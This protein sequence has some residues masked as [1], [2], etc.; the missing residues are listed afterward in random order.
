TERGFEGGTGPFNSRS[1]AAPISVLDDKV[2][3]GTEKTSQERRRRT[4]YCSRRRFQHH[5]PC[6]AIG[7]Q[8]T[9]ASARLRPSVKPGIG[10]Q[11]VRMTDFCH[12]S[13]GPS[14]R[15]AEGAVHERSEIRRCSL[16]AAHY[17]AALRAGVGPLREPRG[18]VCRQRTWPANN[19]EDQMEVR[20]RFD[21]PGNCVP[22][23][24]GAESVRYDCRRLL[25][26]GGH[27]HGKSPQ[28]GLSTPDVLADRY[29]RICPVCCDAVPAEARGESDI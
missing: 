13:S 8:E 15:R 11:I 14:D 16:R 26:L 4:G 27:L 28:P 1:R 5:P 25:R 21:L 12:Y 19:R 2:G 24:T 23:A 7:S 22:M 20:V 9:L 18:S 29:P 10:R 3:E 6:G 17:A